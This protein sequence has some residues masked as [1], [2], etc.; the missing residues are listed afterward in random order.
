MCGYVGTGHAEVVHEEADHKVGVLQRFAATEGVGGVEPEA[1]RGIQ[2]KEPVDREKSPI[3]NRPRL[4]VLARLP[5][6]QKGLRRRGLAASPSPDHVLGSVHDP[7]FARDEPFRRPRPLRSFD[8][9]ELRLARGLGVDV[10]GR[11]DGV[12][13]AVLECLCCAIDVGVVDGEE[14]CIVFV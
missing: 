12:D 10:D 8:E 4:S 1:D 2:G 13:V 9:V 3:S 11:D 14:V 7:V 5:G 6:K